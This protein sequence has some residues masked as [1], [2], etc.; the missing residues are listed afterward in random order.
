MY[1]VVKLTDNKPYRRVGVQVQERP[2]AR[3]YRVA[4]P[5]DL[6]RKLEYAGARVT[7]KVP[8]GH[9]RHVRRLHG[10]DAQPW[11]HIVVAE[12]PEHQNLWPD[13]SGGFRGGVSILCAHDGR[14]S[15]QVVPYAVRLACENQF[16]TPAVR[17]AHTDPDID[18]ILRDPVPFVNEL[19]E[20]ARVI[21]ERLEELIAAKDYREI[22]ACAV[23]HDLVADR[24]RLTMRWAKAWSEGQYPLTRWGALQAATAS[25]QPTLVRLA[26]EALTEKWSDVRR[27]WIPDRS[28]W[29]AL[30]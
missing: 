26:G 4:D 24:K 23:L 28:K 16:V 11:K 18:A 5:Y 9:I 17:V 30:N 15:L 8:S 13:G 29:A 22:Y 10:P 12:Q 25:R 27:F 2:A 19:I 3:G 6:A 20:R 21:P 1:D 14:T 7:V